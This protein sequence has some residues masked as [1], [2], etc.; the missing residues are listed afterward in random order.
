MSLFTYSLMTGEK[1][2][3]ETEKERMTE[4]KRGTERVRD[5]ETEIMNIKIISYKEEKINEEKC[6]KM[7]FLVK[8]K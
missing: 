2:R 3:R 8:N 1:T 5:R 6:Q 7:L 4:K